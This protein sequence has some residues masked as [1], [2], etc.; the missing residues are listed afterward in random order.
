MPLELLH[1]I[2][3][4]ASRSDLTP[5]KDKHRGQTCVIIGNGPS[6]NKIDFKTLEKFITFGV[7][8]IFYKF[9]ELGFVPDYYVVEDTAVMQD[10][11]VRIQ[12]FYG[13]KASFFPTIYKN[14]LRNEITDIFLEWIEDFTKGRS[15]GHEIPQFSRM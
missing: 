5:F 15:Y 8:G 10:N 3:T 12:D 7:N 6:L 14:I 1:T 2:P 13:K 11:V 9:D 4:F